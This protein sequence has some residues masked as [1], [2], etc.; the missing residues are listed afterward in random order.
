M[1]GSV[2]EARYRDLSSK[3][4]KGSVGPVFTIYVMD[5][6]PS[7]GHRRARRVE[8]VERRMLGYQIRGRSRVSCAL[9]DDS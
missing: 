8:A 1:E 3:S 5:G 6:G 7:P 4:R 9:C 2:P